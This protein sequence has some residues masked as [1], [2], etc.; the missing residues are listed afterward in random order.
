METAVEYDPFLA[1]TGA[2]PYAVYAQLRGH[3]P[4]HHSSR[5][6]FYALSRFIES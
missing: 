5:R 3:H 6:G 2:D 1:G 4:L